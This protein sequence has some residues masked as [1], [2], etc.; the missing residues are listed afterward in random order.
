MESLNDQ[1]PSSGRLS[2]L[3]IMHLYNI[4]QNSRSFSSDGQACP[5]R[6]KRMHAKTNHLRFFL[7]QRVDKDWRRRRW[8]HLVI[9]RFALYSSLQKKKQ[10][11]GSLSHEKKAGEQRAYELESRKNIFWNQLPLFNAVRPLYLSIWV[12]FSH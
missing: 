4:L 2:I 9:K 7:G 1:P 8:S 11:C 10:D 3:P 12:Q 6:D 5:P